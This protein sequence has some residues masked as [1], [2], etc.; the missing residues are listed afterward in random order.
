MLLVEAEGPNSR[1][2]PMKSLSDVEQMRESVLRILEH[3]E[4]FGVGQ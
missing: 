2:E 4:I 1:F 3:R